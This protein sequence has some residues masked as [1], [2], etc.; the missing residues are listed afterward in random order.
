MTCGRVPHNGTPWAAL[1]RVNLRDGCRV[2]AILSHPY[3]GSVVELSLVRLHGKLTPLNKS[4]L[5]DLTA[6]CFAVDRLFTNFL[7]LTLLLLLH[8]HIFH[9]LESLAV[10]LVYHS[11]ILDVEVS[12]LYLRT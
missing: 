12:L 10:F 4:L 3:E 2:Y 7:I 11:L 8:A 1:S 9:F 5:L 6:K